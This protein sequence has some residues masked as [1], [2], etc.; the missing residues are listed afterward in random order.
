[1]VGFLV[2]LFLMIGIW[3]FL[4]SSGDTSEISKNWPKYRCDITIMPFASFYGHDAT[5]NFN[6][7]MKNMMN[8]EAGP[9]L[10]PV[11]QVIA[12]LLGTLASLISVANSIRLEFATFMGGV[13]T[14]FQNFTD[15]FK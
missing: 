9:L 6:F 13:N 12:T 8:V 7:C 4:L 10:S 1:M 14:I 11:F 3:Y 15:R 2:L 5:E